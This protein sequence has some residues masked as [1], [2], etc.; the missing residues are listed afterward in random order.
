MSTNGRVERGLFAPGNK[1]GQG[2]PNAKRM[3][4]LR[5]SLLE[6]ATPRDI[7]AV[8]AKLVELAKDGDVA[9]A[10]IWLEFT[11]GKAT[12]PIEVSGPD[13][14][15]LGASVVLSAIMVALKDDPSARLKVAAA[16]RKLSLTGPDEHNGE[17]ESVE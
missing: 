10:K 9:A 17:S 15:P 11:C 3:Y 2:N 8:A 1:I 5:R 12:Q 6:S 4:E 16:F 7:Q 14:E 13:G